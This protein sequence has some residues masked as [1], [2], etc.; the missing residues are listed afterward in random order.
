MAFPE[1]KRAAALRG[2]IRLLATLPRSPSPA[3]GSTVAWQGSRDLLADDLAVVRLTWTLTTERGEAETAREEAIEIFRRL[4]RAIAPS[5]PFPPGHGRLVRLDFSLTSRIF[6]IHNKM[7]LSGATCDAHRRTLRMDPRRLEMTV[8][9][10]PD[11]ANFS[12]KVHGGALLNLLDRVA[13]SCASR[14]SGRYAVTLSVDQVTFKEPIN[15]GELVTFRASVNHAGRTS[16]EV[17]IRVEAENI[18][19][20]TAGTP[21]PATSPWSRSTTRAARRRAA[22]RARGPGRPPPPRRRRNPPQ[23]PPR[24][25]RRA[26]ARRGGRGMSIWSWDGIVPVIDPTAFVHPDATVIGDVIIGA[27]VYVGPQCVL[28]GD[29]G[30]ITIGP[31]ANVQETCVVHSFPNLE[32]EIGPSGHIGHGAV[33]HGC[34]IGRNAMVGMNAV[35]MDEAEVGENSIVAAM[36]FVKAGAV[37]P[38]RSLAMGSPARVTR[39]LTDTARSNGKPAAQAFTSAWHWRRETSSVPLSRS[40]NPSP[41]VA[42]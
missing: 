8:L 38:P 33:L 9:M 36:A 35:V 34:R 37:I 26:R 42:V 17:G 30:R 12:G 14:Y 25:R 24:D 16:M 23:P 15:V 28:R 18:R 3:N 5:S 10:T 41:N 20:G 19:S 2:T 22:A 1:V 39:E 6:S 7:M 40:A 21:T 11:M 27:G 4:R 29:F 31:G 13:F 32:V